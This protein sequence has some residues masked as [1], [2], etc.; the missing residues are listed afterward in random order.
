MDERFK[1]V[2]RVISKPDQVEKLARKI[3]IEQSVECPE[4]VITEHIEQN[5]VPRVESITCVSEDSDV[6]DVKL[7]YA[8]QVLSKQFNQL[9]NICFGNVSMYPDV[10]LVDL[11]I[12]D[13]LLNNFA[14]PLYGVGRI[15]ESLGINNRP[16]LATALKP[17]GQSY[18]YFADLTLQFA[19]AGGDIIK[20]DQN[21]LGDFN[22]FKHRTARC[23]EA[24]DASE[25][26][27]GR[28][29]LYF[30]FIS[31]PFEQLEQYF[32]WVKSLDLPGVLLCPLILGLDT[33]RGLI[34]KYDLMYMAH[35]AFTGSYC[36]AP[37]QG[38][39]YRLLYGLLY[40][41]AGVDISV[42]PNQ[43]GRFSFT[44]TNCKSIANELTRP[45]N[46]INPAFPCPAGGMQY[47]DLGKMC[48]WFG[49]DSVFLLGGSL[50]EY[51]S[52][53]YD[54]TRAFKEKIEE[55]F[56]EE[57]TEP[58]SKESLSS[59]EMPLIIDDHIKDHLA[60]DDFQWQGRTAINYKESD[61]D[62]FSGI[63]RVELIGKQGEQT[64]FD[65][66]YFEIQS[67][68]YSSLETHSHAHVIIVAKGNGEV[69]IDNVTYQV[70]VNDI[71]YVRP[72]AT[73]QL[74][75]T[76]DESFGFYCIVDRERDKPKIVI[77]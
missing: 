31:A 30:P 33:A 8:V 18:D 59:C 9:L 50:L 58:K 22:D 13:N 73:H 26:E 21:L 32:D 20:D 29:C 2:F 76:S 75:N 11:E 43:G 39:S 74:K 6:Y 67:R 7:S 65:L 42:F 64:Q 36:V 1:V 45:L 56:S 63:H 54:S 57:R 61:Q 14:G 19:K 23:R 34:K 51:S 44:E 49:S 3:A 69:L 47:H 48:D 68:G 4:S 16:L 27:T 60:F 15:R 25:Q 38:M 71:V 5:F 40:R 70:K 35:P 24:V 46:A 10:R 53:V 52:Y 37:Y 62:S 55:S 41:L 72:N 28:R 66:R 77:N 17:R 12:P